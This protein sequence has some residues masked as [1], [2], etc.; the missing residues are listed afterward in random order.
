[1]LRCKEARLFVDT[2]GLP[3]MPLQED[4]AGG[5]TET[6]GV[7]SPFQLELART[8]KLQRVGVRKLRW[9]EKQPALPSVLKQSPST[10]QANCKGK[11]AFNSMTLSC[12]FDSLVS[13]SDS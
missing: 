6:G 7:S 13:I 4:T 9:S 10:H 12:S 2:S 11:A 3:G 5:L 1:M 8:C